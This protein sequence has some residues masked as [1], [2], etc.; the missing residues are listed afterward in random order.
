MT[1]VSEK[2][3]EEEEAEL[4]SGDWKRE[5]LR[6]QWEKEEIELLKKND[7]HY[8]DLLFNEART[9][10]VGYYG[11]SRDEEER[12]KQ[13]E[14]LRKL[15]EETEAEQKRAQE[16]RMIREKQLKAR[17]KA[18][19]DRRRARLG[20][21]PGGDSEEE[22]KI[23]DEKKIEKEKD[24]LEISEIDIEKVSKEKDLEEKR[25]RHVRP[26]DIGKEG[27]LGKK[28][29]YE[30][31]QEEWVD[32]KRKER[33]EEFAPPTSYNLKKCGKKDSARTSGKDSFKLTDTKKIST[34]AGNSL[35]VSDDKE[36]MKFSDMK[37][38]SSFS[39]CHTK[40]SFSEEEEKDSCK[41]SLYFS[42]KSSESSSKKKS[43]KRR[44]VFSDMKDEDQVQNLFVPTLIQNEVE[45]RSE[46]ENDRLIQDFNVVKKKINSKSDSSFDSEEEKEEE[47]K[48]QS[49]KGAEV[50]PPCSFD[51]YT[52]Q[53][54]R[55]SYK[56]HKLD[57]E[58]S[59]AAGLKFLREQIEKKEAS[60]KNPSEVFL[61]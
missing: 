38:P 45:N 50:P 53:T 31:T 19:R 44:N 27:V 54:K 7:V 51:Y 28:E 13:Q 3:V 1:M 56:K 41:K 23:E 11:F 32:R 37:D 36:P 26:W 48:R 18:A 2:T 15:R 35:R 43:I 40:S 24:D 5:Q 10:G 47:K 12:A 58:D 25:K 22:E 46:D 60:K 6:R 21:P 55:K 30:Y 49:G 42:T 39:G 52:P 59:I 9:H 20:L 16:L 4:I 34:K 8:Q 17:A 57:P 14:N 33:V 29:H 61:F